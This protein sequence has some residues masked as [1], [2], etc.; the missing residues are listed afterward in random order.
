MISRPLTRKVPAK[1]LP[2][3]FVER[4]LAECFTSGSSPTVK[5]LARLLAMSQRRLEKTFLVFV[6]INPGAYL[7][8]R[9]IEAAKL[10]LTTTDLSLAAVSY[11]TGFETARTFFRAFRRCVGVSPTTYRT[12]YKTDSPQESR[13]HSG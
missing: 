6:G 11:I 10:L 4:Y 2:L 3:E 13:A 1:R 5:E 12:E 8:A 7:K 9:Q